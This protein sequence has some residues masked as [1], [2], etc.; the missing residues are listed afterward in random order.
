LLI[1]LSAPPNKEA[2]AMKMT[3]R[4]IALI[5]VAAI[6]GAYFGF[7]FPV[8]GLIA[9]VGGLGFAAFVLLGNKQGTKADP[10][11]LADA[12]TLQP[13]NGKARIYVMRK[14]FVGGMQGMNISIDDSYNGQIRSNYFMMAELDPGTY[15]MSAQFSKQTASTRQSHVVTITA[16]DVVLL[17][18][19]FDLGMLQ[20]T[21]RF[22]ETRDT[23]QIK[24]LLSGLK[25]VNWLSA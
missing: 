16:G 15:N 20:G 24:Q 3:P 13:A 4:N 18:M 6:F 25:M 14:G 22:D 1:K 12:L 7:Q 17:N 21:I 11:K 5:T 23:A 10:A 9:M 8:I 2:N 19:T